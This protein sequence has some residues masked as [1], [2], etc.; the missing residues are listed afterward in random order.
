MD[1]RRKKS[2]DDTANKHVSNQVIE[3]LGGKPKNF[4]SIRASNVFDNKWRVDVFCERQIQGETTSVT[5]TTIDYSYF[6]S[7]DEDNNI[8]KSEPEIDITDNLIDGRGFTL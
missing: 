4:H 6:I 5:N 8:V 2:T 3:K 7:V 1:R